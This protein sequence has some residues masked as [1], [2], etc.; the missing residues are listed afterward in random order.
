MRIQAWRRVGR[1]ATASVFL[2]A[3]GCAAANGPL[4]VNP[5]GK[6]CFWP[7][8]YEAPAERV[9]FVI[10]GDR[11][12]GHVP[13]LTA[14]AIAEVNALRPEFVL[15]VGDQIEGYIR[16]RQG[17][18]PEEVVQLVTQEWVEYEDLVS[19]FAVPYFYAVGNHDMWDGTSADIY[20]SRHGPPYYSFT[21]KGIHVVVL[22]SEQLH[23][24]HDGPFG[25]KQLAWLE[26]D[27][28][29]HK[30]ARLTVL[31]L[32]KPYWQGRMARRWKPVESLLAG[33]NYMVVAGH[34]HSYG[35]EVR[36]GM[37]YVVVGPV[38]AG[39]RRVSDAM[40]YL[41][42]V[43]LVTVEDGKPH[44]AV[45]RL[46][47]VL[48]GEAIPRAGRDRLRA[49]WSNSRMVYSPVDPGSDEPVI[50]RWALK[51]PTNA[52]AQIAASWATD[53]PW[54]VEP[55]TFS[56]T[57]NPGETK[58]AKFQARPRLPGA[59]ALP[60]AQVQFAW[61]E[62]TQRPM[63]M[64]WSPQPLRQ[65][66]AAR[67]DGLTVDGDVEPAWQ[68]AE[69]IG[70]DRAEY[71][72]RGMADLTGSEDLAVRMRAA[73]DDKRLFLLVQV[74]DDSVLAGK[75]ELVVCIAPPPAE[76]ILPGSSRLVYKLS[77]RPSSEPPRPALRWISRSK[78]EQV[79]A[80]VQRTETG[81]Q[82]ELSLPLEA[83][84]VRADSRASLPFTIAV[85]DADADQPQATTVLW[86]GDKTYLQSTRDWGVLYVSP[87][88][89]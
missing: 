54:Q 48:A 35:Y 50:I 40:G 41:Q 87:L 51:N 43:T 22:N 1:W 17:Y 21:V 9:Q 61:P 76:R 23:V 63:S 18:S 60:T 45:I 7:K 11:T 38:G 68:K 86:S 47:S 80:A 73:S 78:I 70:L 58:M 24:D 32:H 49:I 71:V 88:A 26:R 37:P 82:A 30:D 75:D 52:A 15:A 72:I 65:M 20:A 57:L 29:R 64:A 3:C 53:S 85:I 4:T 25:K 10:F 28:A 69:A 36:N 19:R 12:G 44:L 66:Q 83:L 77:V 74:Q 34:Q 31:V 33:R 6:A 55:V 67:I 81:W 62:D 46:G 84:R 59:S 5:V 14:E 39:I 13:G 56:V 42:H 2:L 16:R 79:T 8:G 89:E 27:L